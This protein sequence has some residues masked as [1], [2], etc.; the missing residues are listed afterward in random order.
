MQ[1]TGIAAPALGL[2][3]I[4]AVALVA[5]RVGAL[6]ARA[7][8]QPEVV[9]EVAAGLL[10]GPAAVWL[11]GS[12]RVGALL[13]SGALTGAKTVA[14]VGL[15]LFLLAEVRDLGLHRSAPGD[16]RT[17]L[18]VAAGSLVAPALCGLL[19]AWWVSG[20]PVLRGAAPAAAFWLMVPVSLAITAVPVLARITARRPAGAVGRTALAAAVLIDAVTWVWLL[21]AIGTAAGGSDRWVRAVLVLGG[22]LLVAVLLGWALRTGPARALATGLPRTAALVLAAAVVVFALALEHLGLTVIVGAVLAG[23]AVPG[24]ADRSW[25]PPVDL[26]ARLGTALVP[27]FFV[28]T[29]LTVLTGDLVAPGAL[30]LVGTFALAA[31]GKLAGGYLGARAAGMGK[32]DAIRTGALMNTR[33]L[34]EI[35]VIQVGFTSGVLTAPMF[36]ALLVMALA[37]TALTGP[38]LRAVD[39]RAPVVEPGAPTE[40]VERS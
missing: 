26:L 23:L 21:V 22:A 35:V 31:V 12:G 9:G 29:G 11:L 4:L 14:E 6:L 25:A 27:L 7:L 37:T 1:P 24:G 10:C 16:R 8:R 36:L 40:E 2:L 38:L 15:V 20:D 33:G 32:P 34:T 28:V 19:L 39:N 30:L 18:L 3:G 5:A 13:D 17:T